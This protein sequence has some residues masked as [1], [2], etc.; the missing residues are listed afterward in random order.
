[1]NVTKK[2]Y[3]VGIYDGKEAITIDGKINKMYS[4][5]SSM[6]GRCYSEAQLKRDPSYNGV[7]V[8][9]EWLTFSNFETWVKLHPDWETKE[10][11]K[12][13]KG[14]S[15]YSPESCLMIT[16]ELNKFLSMKK[17][18][19]GNLIGVGYE[20]DRRKWKASI[21]SP[22]TGKKITLGRFDTELDAHLCW[23][24][25]KR[26]YLHTFYGRESSCVVPSLEKLSADMQAHLDKKIGWTFFGQTNRTNN[27]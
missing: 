17:Q 20:K 16:P 2:V 24:S 8:C 26:E 7:T 13:I 21:S 19:T 5:W 10:I 22:V 6:L 3:G 27:I 23:L 15:L 1:M 18:K 14:V 4:K 25:A 11:D 9:E 12:D